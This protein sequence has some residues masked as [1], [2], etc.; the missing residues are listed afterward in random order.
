MKTIILLIMLLAST[1]YCADFQA[2]K[3]EWISF[4]VEVP[5]G[6]L[7]GGDFYNLK[8]EPIDNNYTSF[9]S[10]IKV[11]GIDLK[12]LKTGEFA[13]NL[14]VTHITKGTCA[15]AHADEYSNRQVKVRVAE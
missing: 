2:V 11:G 15:S 10:R 5:E 9:E 7:G 14:I 4:P 12:F 13:V 6:K 8:A 1:A 3:G